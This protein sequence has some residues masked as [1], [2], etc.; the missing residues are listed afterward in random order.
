M[1]IHIDSNET[2]KQAIGSVK[3][4][5]FAFNVSGLMA[6]QNFNLYSFNFF[7]FFFLIPWKSIARK[8]V[9]NLICTAAVHRKRIIF[10]QIN[11]VHFII[12]KIYTIP[13]KKY[14]KIKNLENDGVHTSVALQNKIKMYT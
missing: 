7:I 4:I 6:K 3:L 2:D 14:N 1:N 13:E 12:I 9:Y 5:R 11:S 8:L 10:G